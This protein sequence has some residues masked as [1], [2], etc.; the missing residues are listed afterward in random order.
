MSAPAKTLADVAKWLPKELRG[1]REALESALA[2]A[3]PGNWPEGEAFLPA[4]Q[5]EAIGQ[6]LIEAL[7]RELRP[8]RMAF[9]F[10]KMM[11]RGG[12]HLSLA[13]MKRSSGL[14]LYLGERDFVMIVNWTSW[15]AL[16]VPQ[17][18]AL[19]DHELCHAGVEAEN[20]KW[21]LLHHDVEEFGDVVRRWGLWL[22]DLKSFGDVL[23]AQLEIFPAA[24]VIDAVVN[25]AP[26]PGSGIDSVTISSGDQEVT[27]RKGD[28]EKIRRSLEVM[29]GGREKPR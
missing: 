13:K 29:R 15:G 8:A 9:V 23:R 14:L 7:H 11:R 26:E 27:L 21:I 28:G 18:I 16:E 6:A 10:K 22:P 17:R 4:E 2:T 19:I 25:L 5:P 24:A 3:V 12:A 1:H 20:G